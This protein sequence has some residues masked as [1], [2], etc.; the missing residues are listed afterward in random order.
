M[1]GIVPLE[2]L[3]AP[4]AEL[5]GEAG[6]N[7]APADYCQINAQHDLAA[8]NIWLSRYEASPHTFRSHR[9][10]V[11]RL[12]LWSITERGKPISSMSIED[13]IAFRSFL[14]DPQ[15]AE[16]WCGAR[17]TRFSDKWRPF[18]KGLGFSS[19]KHA[20]TVAGA[21][22][23]WLKDMGYLRH[24]PWKGLARLRGSTTSRVERYINQIDWDVVTE[25]LSQLDCFDKKNVRL[26]FIVLAFYL[27]RCRLAELATAKMDDIIEIQRGQKTQWWLRVTG[28]GNKERE[29]PIPG[30]MHQL[31][32]Y[33]KSRELPE[34]PAGE[35]IPLIASI[36]GT[37]S[38]TENMIHRELTGFFQRLAETLPAEQGARIAGATAHWLRH[39]AASHA[40][41]RG[42]SLKFVQESLGHA[43]LETTSVYLHADRDQ[44]YE[45]FEQHGPRSIEVSDE[46][47]L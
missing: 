3:P 1:S 5:S 30:L 23:S 34:R 9:K 36:N 45:A 4:P 2:Q 7:R 39:S 15:P 17:T 28:K 19:R 46:K 8:I 12:L 11:E 24:N 18:E 14:I 22:F 26:H 44:L 10:E 37:R 6:S 29:V 16:L 32:T 13:C 35:P 40:V 25:A 41:D 38:V 31:M 21:M 27:S 43:S 42:E 33:R 20:E 47:T